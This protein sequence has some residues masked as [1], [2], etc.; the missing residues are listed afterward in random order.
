MDNDI[1]LVSLGVDDVIGV[2]HFRFYATHFVV[3]TLFN[4]NLLDF[5]E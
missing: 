1:I 5:A 2:K 3:L 4:N